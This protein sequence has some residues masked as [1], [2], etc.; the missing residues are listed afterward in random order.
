[1]QSLPTRN[2]EKLVTNVFRAA[3]PQDKR[4]WPEVKTPI[5]SKKKLFPIKEVQA[6]LKEMVGP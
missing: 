1:M 2:K 5:I 3:Q 6:S 4:Q